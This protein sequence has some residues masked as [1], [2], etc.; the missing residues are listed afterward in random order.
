VRNIL[1]IICYPIAPSN[2]DFDRC[3]IFGSFQKKPI[4]KLTDGIHPK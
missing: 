3:A 4:E 1:I 2:F